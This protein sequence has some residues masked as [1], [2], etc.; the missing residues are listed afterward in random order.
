[1]NRAIARP[2]SFAGSAGGASPRIGRHGLRTRWHVPPPRPGG[3]RVEPAGQAARLPVILGPPIVAKLGRSRSAYDARST[4]VSTGDPQPGDVIDGRYLLER[5]IGRGGHGVVFAST[6]QQT[7]TRVALKLLRQNIAEDPQFAVRLWREAQSL[8]TLW[9][10]SVVRV[11]GFGHDAEGI[12]LHGDGAARRRDARRS[13]LGSRGLRR[14]HERLRG[15]ARSIRSRARST[16]AHSKGI[17]HRDVKPANIFLI[18][19]GGRRRRSPDGLRPRQ[20]P[21]H[22]AAH[23]GRA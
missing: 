11:H 14:P 9:G 21:R 19:P 12:G 1:M 7:G 5:E 2:S 13:P 22:G 6:D 20:D 17:I 23:P 10:E 16:C 8:Q 18:D 4:Q 3:Q 15:A